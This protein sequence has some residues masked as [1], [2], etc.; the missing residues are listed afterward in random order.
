M[1]FFF[2]ERTLSLV[3]SRS[4]DIYQ[5]NCFSPNFRAG[6]HCKIH[7]VRGY[8]EFWPVTAVTATFQ[9][10]ISSFKISNYIYNKTLK[11][12]SL[13]DCEQP[14]FFI[15]FSKGSARARAFSGE[16]ARREKRE[17]RAAARE[18][19][20]EY[21]FY[22]VSPVSRLQSRAWSFLSLG[23][24]GRRTKKKERLLLV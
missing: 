7:D 20:I 13:V 16:A 22:C 21:L 14:L 6:Q 23:R 5:W 4:H 24:F 19:K 10:R 12:W 3:T 11:D 17:T 18:E 9:Q 15:R 1:W 8:R 2:E